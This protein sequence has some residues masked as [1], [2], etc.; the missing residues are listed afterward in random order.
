MDQ[1]E[2]IRDLFRKFIKEECSPEEVGEL[3]EFLR[4]NPEFNPLPGDDADRARIAPE[5]L[6]EI[7]ERTGM[8]YDRLQQLIAD[9]SRGAAGKPFR[10]RRIARAATVLCSVGIVLFGSWWFLLREQSGPGQPWPGEE[11]VLETAGEKRVLK[12]QD[13]VL[14]TSRNSGVIGVQRGNRLDLTAAGPGP[15]SGK[16]MLRLYVPYGRKFN[17]LLPDST[18]VYLNAGSSITFPSVFDGTYREVALDGEAYFDVSHNARQ[19]FRVKAEAL[20]VEV[21]GTRF[22]VL[23]YPEDEAIKVALVQGKVALEHQGN[24]RKVYLTPGKLGTYRKDTGQTVVTEEDLSYYT[25]WKDG[26]LAFR[27]MSLKNIFKK[28]E[29]QYNVSIKIEDSG[30]AE[31]QFYVH[32]KAE[33]LVNILEYFKKAYGLHYTYTDR[34]NI[35]ITSKTEI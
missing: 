19:P 23:S 4:G 14:I 32:F 2:H 20:Q 1:N 29:R 17:L 6:F 22:N 18:E 13:S 16:E 11:I 34:K 35:V 15:A 21:L 28:L 25:S 27:N 12:E 10:K 31:K 24:A 26:K 5:E 7:Q 30:L 8:Q 3:L 33:P 9:R